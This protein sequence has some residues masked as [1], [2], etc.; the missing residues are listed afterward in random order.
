MKNLLTALAVLL[1]ATVCFASPLTSN[2]RAVIPASAQQI[3]C[4]DYRAMHNSP[5]AMD[6]KARV[7]P[8]SLKEVEGSLREMGIDPDKDVDQLTFVSFRTQKNGLRS[9]GIAQGELN[10]KQV[11]ANFKKRK[12][13][14]AK[15]LNNLL[16]PVSTGIQMTFLDDNTIL[17]GEPMSVKDGLS[18]Q[19]GDTPNLG[20]APDVNDEI[21]NAEDAPVW[22]VL[23]SQGTQTMLR[24]ALGDA[25]KLADY[26]TVKKRV[27][28]SFYTLD[29][30]RG[31]HFNLMVNMSDSM[32]ATTLATLV[33]AGMMYRK[34]G[35]SPIEKNAIN[36]MK[37][38]SDGN[39]L[40]LKYDS[41][42]GQF[43][44]LLHS[45]LFATVSR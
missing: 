35:S 11:L 38:D 42:D 32:T 44:A 23:D 27:G 13:L 36:A 6:L 15:Y 22:S 28:A 1:A 7:L 19:N 5:T 8:E 9:F 20:S 3:I 18:A 2:G 40:T 12:V 10:R 25:S 41:D 24:N 29:F 16:Y 33:K 21:A 45:D 31:V 37:V 4:V 43:Q 39:A 30:S 17:F 14:G 26:D 34:M